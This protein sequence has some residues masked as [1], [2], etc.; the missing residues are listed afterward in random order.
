MNGSHTVGR[1]LSHLLPVIYGFRRSGGEIEAS[2]Y[3]IFSCFGPPLSQG[4]Y[5]D[6]AN[7]LVTSP[8]FGY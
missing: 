1:G 4:L 2:R 5:E 3:F 6:G 7:N 8:I